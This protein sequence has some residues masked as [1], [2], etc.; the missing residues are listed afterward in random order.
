[1]GKGAVVCDNPFAVCA[2]AFKE[3]TVAMTAQISH[4]H[5]LP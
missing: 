3:P 1:M 5:A 2:T 4:P